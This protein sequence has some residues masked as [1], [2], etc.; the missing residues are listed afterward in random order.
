MDLNLGG[1]SVLITGASRGIGKAIAEVMAQEGCHLHLA[2]RDGALLHAVCAEIS[3]KYK[4][5]AQPHIHDLSQTAQVEQLGAACIDVDILVN[6]AGGIPHGPIQ[7]IDG[8]TWRKAWDLK[9][10]GFIDLTR[11]IFE[12][13][14]RRQSGAI[15]NVIGMKG[16][17]PDYKYIAGSAGNAALNAVTLALGGES[18]RY[19][20]RVNCVNPGLIE[21]DRFKNG[22]LRRARLAKMD[23]SR[24]PELLDYLPIKRAGTPKEVADAVAF[25]ASER[26]S[27]ISGTALRIDAG[28]KHRSPDL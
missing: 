20:V 1:K 2:A 17:Q 13:M 21:S 7:E 6:N 22:M 23:E 3:A 11:I 12:Q 25:L 19:G 27:Y 14:C 5:E 15:V 18:V 4:V 9:V 8:R 10:F 24:W 28:L 26:A 16:E